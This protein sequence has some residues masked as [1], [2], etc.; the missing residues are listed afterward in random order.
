MR[1]NRHSEV[2]SVSYAEGYQRALKFG[3][4][5]EAGIRSFVH[6]AKGQPVSHENHH[7]AV[8]A[9]YLEDHDD[10]RHLIVRRHLDATKNAEGGDP[11]NAELERQ[12]G[13]GYERAHYHETTVDTP[14]GLVSSMEYHHPETGQRAFLTE[15]LATHPQSHTNRLYHTVLS[16]SE[17]HHVVTKL[18][19][20]GGRLVSGDELPSDSP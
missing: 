9:D 19:E 2:T 3:R 20:S 14:D 17:H 1:V 8:L 7:D 12:L 11:L 16:P 5:P 18:V 4:A 10:P 6:A 15:W 13:P